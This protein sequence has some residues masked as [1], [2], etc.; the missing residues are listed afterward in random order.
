MGRWYIGM[1]LSVVSLVLIALMMYYPMFQPWWEYQIKSTYK[2]GAEYEDTYHFSLQKGY[3]TTNR[4][5][6]DFDGDGQSDER[7]PMYSYNREYVPPHNTSKVDWIPTKLDSSNI[8]N[9]M[10][11]AMLG[12][13]RYGGRPSVLTTWTN[14]YYL[15]IIT[16]V[17]NIIAIVLYPLAGFRKIGP[18][19]PK[20][21]TVIGA[22]LILLAAFYAVFGIPYAINEDYTEYEKELWRQSHQGTLTG[23]IHETPNGSDFYW[24]G[25][26]LEYPPEHPSLVEE[27][28]TWGAGLGWYLTIVIFIFLLMASAYVYPSPEKEIENKGKRCPQCGGNLKWVPNRGFYCIRCMRYFDH[29]LRLLLPKVNDA[30]HYESPMGEESTIETKVERRFV[31][32]EEQP[33]SKGDEDELEW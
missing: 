4:P 33:V 2:T 21:L 14:I 15:V 6:I 5:N 11:F 19:A 27:T 1:T 9:D 13:A 17:L 18:G 29:E 23:Y 28:A 26:T 20:A 25:L 24:S 7:S 31:K 22:L 3:I 30:A 32:V 10:Y 8:S 16:L 12:D